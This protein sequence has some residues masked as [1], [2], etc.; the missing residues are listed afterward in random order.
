MWPSRSG[1]AARRQHWSAPALLAAILAGCGTAVS[2]SAE[3]SVS[4]ASPSQSA[5]ESAEPSAAPSVS[6]APSAA[7][8]PDT[9]IDAYGPVGV[10]IGDSLRVRSWPGTSV[11]DSLL[12]TLS[13]GDEV[14]LSMGP[15]DLDGFRWYLAWFEPHPFANSQGTLEAGWIATG[16]I[17]DADQFVQIHG[18]RCPEEETV[19]ALARLGSAGFEACDVEVTTVSGIVETCYE[20]PLSP[21]TYSPGWA[22]FSCQSLRTE[23]QAAWSYQFFLPPDYDGPTLSRGDVVTLTGV[24]GVD[25]SAYGACEVSSSEVE[26]EATLAAVN[27]TWALECQYRFVVESAEV[28]GHVE[29]PPLF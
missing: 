2:P 4:E 12:T 15:I 11:P 7:A 22:Y 14:V 26:G 9:N 24:L 18:A 23:D 1:R 20:G 28:T 10:V 17:D 27:A 25:E 8:T 5:L 3:P 29:L 21:F 6:E 19:H 16:P 13:E